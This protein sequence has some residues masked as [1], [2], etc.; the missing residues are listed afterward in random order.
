MFILQIRGGS[1]F[2]EFYKAQGM[3]RLL[4]VPGSPQQ[5]GV[6]ERKNRSI[7]NMV[8]SM[9]KSKKMHKEF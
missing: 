9:L 4:I 8:R 3:K 6:V 7:L 1:C 2:N 5:N